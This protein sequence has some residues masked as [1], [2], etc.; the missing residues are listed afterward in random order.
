M[1]VLLAILALFATAAAASPLYRF[2]LVPEHSRATG[3]VAFLGIANASVQ[4]PKMKGKLE[5][6][7]DRPEA[8]AF[9]VVVDASA[10]TASNGLMRRT[11][12]GKDFFDVEEYPTFKF[13]GTSIDLNSDTTAKVTGDLTV[14]NVTK[15]VTL[16]VKFASPP[17][18]SDGTSPIDFTATTRIDRRDFEMTAYQLLVGNKVNIS[19][20]AQMAPR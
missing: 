13:I 16:A 11:L 7:P 1:R 14:R 10:L 4:F 20:A 3:K 17:T 6:W 2:D 5:L 15:P 9:D 19:I 12:K 8:F 18:Q